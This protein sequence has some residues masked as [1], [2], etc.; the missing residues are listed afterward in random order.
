[1]Q[2]TPGSTFAVGSESK[3]RTDIGGRGAEALGENNLI[4]GL[5][6]GPESSEL[7]ALNPRTCI[8]GYKRLSDVQHTVAVSP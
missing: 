8:H 1:M 7:K 2:Q 4:A 6:E 3:I 5:V